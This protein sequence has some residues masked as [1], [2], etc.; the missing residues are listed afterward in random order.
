MNAASL[1]LGEVR[2]Q[3]REKLIDRPTRRRV[4]TCKSS[5]ET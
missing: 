5:L 1:D 3:S 2:E 4:L